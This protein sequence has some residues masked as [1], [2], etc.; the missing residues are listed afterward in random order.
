M[1]NW[2]VLKNGISWREQMLRAVV[3]A[4]VLVLT[5]TANI[6]NAVTAT[7]TDAANTD[8]NGNFSTDGFVKITGHARADKAL[9]LLVYQGDNTTKL[10]YSTSVAVPAASGAGSG[11]AFSIE[12]IGRFAKVTISNA[13]GANTTE[14]NAA[15]YLR[16]V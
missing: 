3:P 4:Q 13:S 6:N 10:D 2:G 14:L 8:A 11:A 9:T 12:V 15:V 16:S 7:L 5:R 1:A